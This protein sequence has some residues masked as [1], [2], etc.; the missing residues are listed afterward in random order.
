MNVTAA[1]TKPAGPREISVINRNAFEAL[2]APPCTK[3]PWYGL[4]G[5]GRNL[6]RTRDAALHDLQRPYWDEAF[7]K[8]GMFVA[9]CLIR[10]SH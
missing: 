4:G 2:S 9:P 8:K 6:H 10:D 7:N 3:G 5:V 1:L